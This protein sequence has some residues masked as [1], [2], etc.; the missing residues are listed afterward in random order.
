MGLIVQKFGGTSIADRI[1]IY[2]VANIIARRIA[3][4]N[5]VVTVVSAQGD[6]TDYLL[7]K[8]REISENPPLRELDALLSTGEQQSAALLAMALR[9][10]GIPAVSFN[11]V[12]AGILTDSNFGDAEILKI[13][14]ENIH[15]FLEK[16]YAVIVTGFQGYDEAGNNT[17]LGRGGSDTSAVAL[18]AALKADHCRI[19]KDVDGIYTADPRKDPS[20]KKMDHLHY[21]DMLALCDAGSGVLQRKSVE[22]AKASDIELQILSSFQRMSGTIINGEH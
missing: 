21:D 1:C 8:A 5:K 12:Q 9:D 17:T 4:G 16:N 6:T 14:V 18:A 15:R 10:L 3:E 13:D 2:N 11:G 22:I 20:A 19:Y 7:A